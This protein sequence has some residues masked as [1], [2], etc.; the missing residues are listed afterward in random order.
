MIKKLLPH[1]KFP[2]KSVQALIVISCLFVSAEVFAQSGSVGIGTESPNDK[3]ILDI[4]SDSK[5][6]L[7]PRLT[8]AQ[9]DA[10]QAPGSSNT[11]INGLL[12]YN[13]SAQRFNYWLTNQWL[14]MSDG[15]MGP[16]GLPGMPGPAGAAGA[17][18]A[19]TP[20]P[21]GAPG[22]PGPKGDDGA[23]WLSGSGAPA[24]TDGDLNDLFL[25][26]ITGDIYKKTSGGWVLA[27]NIKGPIGPTPDNIWL[28]NGNSGTTPGNSGDFLGTRDA[29][30]FVIATNLVDRIR[31][32]AGGNVG[33]GAIAPTRK[34][35]VSGNVK[36]GVSGSTIT[37]IIK[38]R[39]SGNIPVIAAGTSQVVTFPVGGTTV[40]GSPS[41]MVSPTSALP[42]GLLIA[43]ARV[44]ADGTVEVKFTNAGPTA[45]TAITQNFHITIVE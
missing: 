36:L 5:G 21:A 26:T 19:S 16:Q 7:I 17:P 14:D 41:V 42:D 3:T 39:V 44:S 13:V 37:N 23:T 2:K 35:E 22:M 11:D 9:R 27:A 38:E 33:I 15:A 8:I 31:V 45:T 34:F 10:L 40:N 4:V 29:K 28:K 1:F 18:G 43:Y 12:I 6:L 30:D 32:T 25:D 24:A 20:G